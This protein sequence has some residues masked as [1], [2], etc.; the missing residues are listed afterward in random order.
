[1]A[2]A[3]G[4]FVLWCAETRPWWEF[5]RPGSGLAGGTIASLYVIAVVHLCHSLAP[6]VAP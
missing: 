1:M 3:A 4:A 6:V 2:R 5:W